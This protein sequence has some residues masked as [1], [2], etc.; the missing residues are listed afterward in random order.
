[1][2]GDLL[3]V[4]YS[5]VIPVDCTLVSELDVIYAFPVAC[6]LL[7]FTLSPGGS[8]LSCTV[9]ITG[10][11]TLRAEATAE[12]S[13]DASSVRLV[14]EA[15]QSRAPMVRLADRYAVPFTVVSLLN[16]GLP[17]YRSGDPTRFAEVLVVATPC[18]LLIAAPV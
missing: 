12:D 1:T 2:V 7:P 8:L 4:C 11:F 15:V 18:P 16:A 13:S 17:W 3:V 10:P 14:Q 9:N 6:V 5:E